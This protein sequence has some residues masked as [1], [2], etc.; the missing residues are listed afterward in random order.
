MSMPIH[1]I[2]PIDGRYAGKSNNLSKYFSEFALIKYRVFIEVQYLIA[3]RDFG[4]PALSYSGNDLFA[5]LHQWAVHFGP[6]DAMQVK[7][8]EKVTNHDVKAVEYLIKE[9]IIEWGGES[10]V[11]YVH[12]GLTSQDIN[13][14]AF[15]LMI[16]DALFERVLPEFNTLILTLK[17]MSSLYHGIPMLSRTH[18][19]PATPTTLGKEID[20]FIE[21]LDIQLTLLNSL[22]Y[23]AKFGGASGNLNAHK[24]AFPDR[25]WVAFSNQFVNHYLDLKR[26]QKTTQI[27]HYDG[28]ANIFDGL[29][30]LSTILID[31]CRDM[32]SY[33][34]MEYFIQQPIAGEVGS[35]AMPH[36]VNPIDFENAEGNLGLAIVLFNHLSNK[37]PVSRLQRDLTDSTVLRNAGVPVAHLYISLLAIQ[38]GLKKI[39]LNES[40]LKEDLN[41]QW[42]VLAEAIQTILRR[43]GYPNPYEVLKDLTRG[44]REIDKATIHSFISGLSLSD[45]VKEEL[46]ALTPFNY[47]GYY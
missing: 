23:E 20:V 46:I 24:I 47:T 14:T 40:K 33:I 11:E 2:S 28:L 12:F 9:K 43:E 35:S 27:A 44:S 17:E 26:L 45:D 38:Q 34:S 31:F 22:P 39:S 8:I 41:N 15:P 30:R 36:K 37:L 6:E 42:I 7:E 18:G 13:N 29:S 4:I 25:D 21:R 1:S 32:W 3:L 5:S 10:I 19:Q 16:R